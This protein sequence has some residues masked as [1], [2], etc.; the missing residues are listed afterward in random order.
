MSTSL[1]FPA[2]RRLPP[3]MRPRVDLADT[4]LVLILFCEISKGAGGI[5]SDDGPPPA[6]VEVGPRWAP[7]PAPVADA[8]VAAAWASPRCSFLTCVSSPAG[9]PLFLRLGPFRRSSVPCGVELLWSRSERAL[10]LDRLDLA[11]TEGSGVLNS[12]GEP[13]ISQCQDQNQF[14][15][16]ET[17]FPLLFLGSLVTQL[18]I[19]LQNLNQL[20]RLENILFLSSL[21]NN[22]QLTTALL[23]SLNLSD[24][25]M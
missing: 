5:A 2:G 10:D 1:C 24:R 25:S 3:P 14:T 12:I 18:S 19:S 4:G 21:Q 23:S 16:N 6:T 9:S 7:T 17:N 20:L 22:G 15:L 13:L 11:R 8:A